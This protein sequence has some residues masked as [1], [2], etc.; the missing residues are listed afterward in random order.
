MGYIKVSVRGDRCHLILR[1]QKSTTNSRKLALWSKLSDTKGIIKTFTVLA[2]RSLTSVC[3][4]QK[5]YLKEKLCH[6]SP[7]SF[8]L[9][10]PDV[11]LLSKYLLGSSQEN[12]SQ[13]YES[14]ADPNVS[15]PWEILTQGSQMSFFRYFE[16]KIHPVLIR[17]QSF[18][19]LYLEKVKQ[20]TS[21]PWILEAASATLPNSRARE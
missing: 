6:V 12:R 15:S 5:K 19:I 18:P 4:Y 8:V 1:Q 11:L 13:T 3:G 10:Q 2:L 20:P 14:G 7:C 16:G 17:P 21:S 9:A